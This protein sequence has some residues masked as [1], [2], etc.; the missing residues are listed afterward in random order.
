ME[1]KTVDLLMKNI[2]IEH[3]SFLETNSDIDPVFETDKS[4]YIKMIK[5]NKIQLILKNCLKKF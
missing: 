2:L 3:L 1:K 4:R 5:L